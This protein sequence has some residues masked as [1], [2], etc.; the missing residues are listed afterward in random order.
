[1]HGQAVGQLGP[2]GQ[3]PAVMCRGG[4][5]EH[6]GGG[7]QFSRKSFGWRFTR[8]AVAV[9]SHPGELM[10]LSYKSSKSS[11]ARRLLLSVVASAVL[12]PVALAEDA[13][14]GVSGE[15]AARMAAEKEARKACKLEIC[16]AFATPGSG[17]ITC[18]ATKTWAKDE[19]LGRVVAG[20]Y[21]WGY[22]H[23]QCK[24][25]LS[26]DKAMLGKAM[27]EG[28]AKVSF[29]E[30]K[31]ICNVDDADA[32]KGQAF[33]ANVALTPVVS[34]EKGEAK[35]VELQNVKSEGSAVA[36]AAVAAIMAAD[37]LAGVVSSAAAK[38]INEFIY[39]KCAA[40]GVAIAKK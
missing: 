27:S 38:E 15:L 8:S 14:P 29:P 11:V 22:G 32:T 17:T 34:F 21:V 28:A 25:S 7:L 33:S 37:K 9:V 16:K 2:S 30:H 3:Q 10:R 35:S 36:S 6:P 1:M 4:V 18:D 5:S 12:V 24:L 23:M 31:I 39:S 26:L 20:S 40:D 19:I 13:K